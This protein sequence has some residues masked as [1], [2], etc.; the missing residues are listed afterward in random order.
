MASLTQYWLNAVV[1][2]MERGQAITF[3]AT[4]HYGLFAVLPTRNTS[5]TE[6]SAGAGY[7]G[8]ARI[9]LAASMT[10][11]SGTQSDGSTGASNGT[12]D[13]I[14]NN[15]AVSFSASLTAAWSG[16]VGVGQFDAPS[17]GN[18][19]RW[20]AFTDSAGNLI[21]RSFTIGE[22]VSFAPGQ[23]RLYYR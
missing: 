2:A 16:L 4:R 14:T 21:T 7:T 1:D 17:G 15:V 19:L 9:A 23:I 5:G 3:P 11:W 8:Y 22:A 12:R 10:N 13:Y 20:G 6:L 18:L